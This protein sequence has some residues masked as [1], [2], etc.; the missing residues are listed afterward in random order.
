MYTIITE[1][2]ND[3]VV[4]TSLDTYGLPVNLIFFFSL[5]LQFIVDLTTCNIYDGIFGILI[6]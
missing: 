6:K 5:I 2:E 4:Y 1:I 3:D